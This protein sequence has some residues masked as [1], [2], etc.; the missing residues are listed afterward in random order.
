LF[1]FPPKNLVGM[2]FSATGAKGEI[3]QYRIRHK[4]G[5]LYIIG[6]TEVTSVQLIVSQHGKELGLK[7]PVGN[8]PYQHFFAHLQPNSPESPRQ[9]PGYITQID[10]QGKQ[11]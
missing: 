9:P 1:D 8:W 10:L 11:K 7:E 6:N 4:A 3:K 5:G 2:Q